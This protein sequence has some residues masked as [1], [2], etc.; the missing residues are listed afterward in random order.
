[1]PGFMIPAGSAVAFAARRTST[2]SAPVSARIQGTWSRPIAWWWVIVPPAA[3]A[4]GLLSDGVGGLQLALLIVSPVLLL[5]VAGLAMLGLRS[6]QA[7]VAAMDRAWAR[8]THGATPHP[9][10]PTP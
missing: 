5:V 8:L 10:T 4:V 6:I 3:A 1:M 9:P 2:P 7:D